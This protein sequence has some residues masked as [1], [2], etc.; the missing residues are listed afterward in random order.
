MTLNSMNR[1]FPRFPAV[2][3]LLFLAATL[4]LTA[5]EFSLAADIT[6]PP[7]SEVRSAVTPQPAQ[8]SG[9]LYPMVPPNPKAGADIYAEKCAPCHG[10][11]GLGDGPRAAQ[12]ANPVSAL[13]SV[14]LARRSTPARWYT[15]VTQGNLEK[16]MPPF[17]SL[18]DRQRWDVVAYAF[19][20]S[21]T[22]GTVE[23]GKELYQANC[24][25]CH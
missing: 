1:A 5:C 3:I 10:E 4:L 12:L 18:S 8:L 25:G 23:L 7:G 9:P 14:E 20:L 16:F 24:Q 21:I 17:N 22:P 19:T 6:P 11:T 13:G 15:M 2:L